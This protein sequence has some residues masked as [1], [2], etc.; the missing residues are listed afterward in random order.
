M[1]NSI[2]FYKIIF[3][4]VIPALIIVVWFVMKIEYYLEL[5]TLGT[6]KLARSTKKIISKDEYD[7]NVPH[8]EI[9]AVVLVQW[10]LK[11]LKR[12]VYIC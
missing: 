9:I 8:L 3:L 11:W 5:L 4:H 6:M 2:D 1:P 10:V 12:L 7:K